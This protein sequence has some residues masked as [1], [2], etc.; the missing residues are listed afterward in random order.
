M[1]TLKRPGGREKKQALFP[2]ELENKPKLP[3]AAEVSP[4]PI[5]AREPVAAESVDAVRPVALILGN[6]PR[7]KTR[8]DIDWV[9]YDFVA[10]CNRALKWLD[11]GHIK[12]LTHYFVT[13]A[14]DDINTGLFDE[15]GS[16]YH[17]R[18]CRHFN[19]PDRKI[20][21]INNQIPADEYVFSNHESWGCGH[22]RL[23]WKPD[24]SVNGRVVLYRP[25]STLVTAVDYMVHFEKCKTLVFAGMTYDTKPLGDTII[26]AMQTFCDYAKTIGVKVLTLDPDSSLWKALKY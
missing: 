13:D 8:T 18:F 21:F 5:P 10:S 14:G 22:S 7:V 20:K 16:A 6:D 24:G 9:S 26:H 19:S 2:P 25:V 1:A 15:P 23:P 3:P 4:E 17:N 11:E 12:R